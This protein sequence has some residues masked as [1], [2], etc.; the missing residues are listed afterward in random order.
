MSLLRNNFFFKSIIKSLFCVIRNVKVIKYYSCCMIFVIIMCEY[1]NVLLNNEL[2]MLFII[3]IG[4][5]L[6]V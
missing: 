6:V 4:C 5:N 1:F 2:N 3:K